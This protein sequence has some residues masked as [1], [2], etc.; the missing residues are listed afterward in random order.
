MCVRGEVALIP[1]LEQSKRITSNVLARRINAGEP[2]GE[3]SAPSCLVG[4]MSNIPP[5]SKTVGLGRLQE[6]P[7]SVNPVRTSQ[8]RMIR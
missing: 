5:F 7:A 1:S 3:Y 6:A 2:H 8:M 4:G